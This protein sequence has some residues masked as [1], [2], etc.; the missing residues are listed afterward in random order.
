MN[1]VSPNFMRPVSEITSAAK[2][3]LLSAEIKAKQ[4]IAEAEFH[5]KEIVASAE[6]DIKSSRNEFRYELRFGALRVWRKALL[7]SKEDLVLF[8]EKLAR[9]VLGEELSNS[10]SSILSRI[11]YANSL[12]EDHSNLILKISPK[13]FEKLSQLE[14]TNFAMTTV[15][16][17]DVIEGEFILSSK[18]FEIKSCPHLQLKELIETQLKS[19]KSFKLIANDTSALRS[20]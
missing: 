6:A 14:K 8:S 13:D 19:N 18:Y 4:I 15:A 2:A 3:L 7:K 16:C 17:A 11:Q 10:P 9:T 12:V 20:K 5:A 1:K